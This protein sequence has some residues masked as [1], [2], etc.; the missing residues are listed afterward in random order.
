MTKAK[1]DKTEKEVESVD[2]PKAARK[3]GRP[4]LYTP[5]E[6]IAR[7]KERAKLRREKKKALKANSTP[8][9]MDSDPAPATE[10]STEV[11]SEAP[12]D[13]VPE[14]VTAE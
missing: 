12:N 13:K 14:P 2:S 5:E 8:A 11:Y 6:R 3:P 7:K 9:S 10:T 1:A 4:A